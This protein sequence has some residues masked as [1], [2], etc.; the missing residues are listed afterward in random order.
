MYRERYPDLPEEKCLLIPNGYDEQD[1]V[2]LTERASVKASANTIVRLLHTGLIYPEERDPRPFFAALS[3][4][5]RDGKISHSVLRVSFRAAGSESLF[6]RMIDDAGISD[7]VELQPHVPYHQALQECLDADALLVF[8]AANCDHQI[9]AKVYEYLRLRKPIFALTSH[10][11]DTAALLKDIGGATIVNLSEEQ[12]IYLA[13]PDFL[14]AVRQGLHPLPDR[15]KIRRYARRTQAGELATCLS[16][17]VGSALS[18]ENPQRDGAHEP[19][20]MHR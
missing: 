5:K 10:S 6:Q 16:N 15:N 8:Q 4:L 11:G 19:A 18:F 9:P 7:L 12:D 14:A 17:I 20:S 13:L 2:G 3:R 1:F